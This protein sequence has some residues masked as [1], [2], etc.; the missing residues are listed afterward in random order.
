[1]KKLKTHIRV[2][3]TSIAIPAKYGVMDAKVVAYVGFATVKGP[4]DLI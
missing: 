4:L 3:Q 1:V 2:L